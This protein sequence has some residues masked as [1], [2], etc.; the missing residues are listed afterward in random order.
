MAVLAQIREAREGGKKRTEQHTVNE[1]KDVFETLTED[2]YA[3]LVQNRRKQDDFVVDDDGLGYYDD[4]EE[5]LF[6]SSFAENR[7]RQ[8]E[9]RRIGALSSESV[10][11]ARLLDLAKKGGPRK[12][13]TTFLPSNMTAI[14]PDS[15][16]KSIKIVSFV[17]AIQLLE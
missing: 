7:K 9:L 17:Y 2:Q 13:S 8:R 12:I 6:D 3:E 10:K 15:A 14:G 1:E 5:H 11:R 4:G 16:N